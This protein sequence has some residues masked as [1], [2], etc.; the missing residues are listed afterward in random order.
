MRKLLLEHEQVQISNRPHSR[1]LLW[2]I[3]VGL[4][5]VMVGSAA[6]EK[7]QPHT[8][9]EWAPGAEPLREPL[10]VCVVV[11]VVLVWLFYPLRR[12]LR[13]TGT[14]YV[15]TNQRLL[16][17]KGLMGRRFQVRA[18]TQI[19]ELRPVQNW[20]QRMVGSGDL[21]LLMHPDTVVVIPEIPHWNEFIKDAQQ[22]WATEFREP[23]QQ[24]PRER[25]YAGVVGMSEKEQRKLGR[26][27]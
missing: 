9:S 5:A 20:R 7:L 11:L 21:E 1:I 23:M 15:L 6:L 4:M 27:H 26:D 8:F 3:S 19:K 25:D 12:V 2:P 10:M 24:T 14:K 16:V 18:L 17:R 13:W 22:F